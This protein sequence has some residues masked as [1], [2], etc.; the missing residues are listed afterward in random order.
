MKKFYS[1]KIFL[2]LAGGGMHPPHP[3]LDPS[4]LMKHHFA[5]NLVQLVIDCCGM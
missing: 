1:S 3:S 5:K 4:L 2:K